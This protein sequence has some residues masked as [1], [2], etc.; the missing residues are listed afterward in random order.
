MRTYEIFLKRAGKDEFRHAGSMQAPDEE[1][2]TILAHDSYC[3]RGEGAEMWLVDR[4]HIIAADPDL[5]ATT[6]DLAHRSNDGSRVAARR[7]RIRE[8][9]SA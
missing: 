4:R 9:D 1:M 6:V 5:L 3:R 7:K 8:G 2:A